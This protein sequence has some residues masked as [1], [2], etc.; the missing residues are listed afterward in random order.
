M[1]LSACS[2]RSRSIVEFMG[3]EEGYI[4]GAKTLTLARATGQSG[5]RFPPEDAPLF[6]PAPKIALVQHRI[7]E[8]SPVG[9]LRHF[10]RAERSKM[11]RHEL[12]VEQAEPALRQTRDEMRQGDFRGAGLAVK[13]AFAEKRRAEV[14]A[15]EPANKRAIRPALHGVDPAG[16]EELAIE[17]SNPA[18]D[19]C[20]FASSMG[21]GASVDHGIEI[22]I[23]SD[24]ETIG[25][26]CLGEAVRYDQ[27]IERENA[28]H[29]R[30]DPEKILVEGA[31]RH[32]K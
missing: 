21:D 7:R 27:A 16:I 19:P 9:F 32:R 8:S 24:L 10:D 26:D 11:R 22:A 30:I 25:A 13:H 29:F 4:R 14:D 15:V 28:A 6:R 2:K 20:L 1:A 17:Q 31:L 23:D 3:E 12:R 18:I 5:E